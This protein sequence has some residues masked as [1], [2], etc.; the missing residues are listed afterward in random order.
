M[1][2]KTRSTRLKSER[3]K[4]KEKEKK[5][6]CEVEVCLGT[7]ECVYIYHS[8]GELAIPFS[9]GLL[10]GS[11]FFFFAKW[12]GT[13]LKHP[14]AR[15]HHHHHQRK[16]TPSFSFFFPYFTFVVRDGSFWM[17]L[18][19]TIESVNPYL[20]WN[21]MKWDVYGRANTK[22][23]ALSSQFLF[24]SVLR[25]TG[26]KQRSNEKERKWVSKWKNKFWCIV[27]IIV[28]QYLEWTCSFVRYLLIYH[29]NCFPPS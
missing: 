7:S 22:F 19:F 20:S 23:A 12:N 15:H 6:G 4:K 26:T 21:E 10:P 2:W 14:K 3:K 9:C 1:K 5:G 8:F 27:T 13:C 29:R 17:T 18:T 11:L 16:P 24:C 25:T 28:H